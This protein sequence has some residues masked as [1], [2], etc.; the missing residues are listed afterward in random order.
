MLERPPSSPAAARARRA[1]ERQR[2]G[3]VVIT[4][5]GRLIAALRTAGR[6]NDLDI[7]LSDSERIIAPVRKCRKIGHFLDSSR[8]K[9]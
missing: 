2:R 1:R 7:A 5:K 8:P 3:L 9:L 6:L 4:N